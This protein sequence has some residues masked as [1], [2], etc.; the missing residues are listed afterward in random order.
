MKV[1]KYLLKKVL[2][3]DSKF[4][5]DIIPIPRF[6]RTQNEPSCINFMGR[7]VS[8]LVKIT[9][10]QYTTYS[11]ERGGWYMRDNTEVCGL[12][13]VGLLRQACGIDGLIGIDRLLCYRILHELHRFVKFFRTNVSKQGVL[14]EQLRDEVSM[15]NVESMVLEKDEIRSLLR[16]SKLF[17][18]WKNPKNAVA[19]YASG[20][21]KTEMLML[22]MLTCFR[23]VGQ[24]QLLRRMIRYELQR[25]ARVD[26]KMLQHTVSTYN[27]AMMSEQQPLEGQPDD[28]KNICDLTVAVGLGHPLETIFMKTDPLEGLPVLMLFFVITYVPKLSF[29]PSLGSLH[30]VKTG[31]PIDGWPIIA[32]ISTLLKQF[33]P[34]YAKSFLAYVGQFIRVS[35]QTYAARRQGKSEDATRLAADLKNTLVLVEQFCDMS[36]LP[37]SALYEH[38]PQYLIDMC[39]DLP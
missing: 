8:M 5:S 20:S 26:A 22:P 30:K 17:P 15:L 35:V 36:G 2:D 1:N 39:S 37:N 24:A 16:H 25:C 4:Q 38:V 32:G 27:T 9:D 3:T 31:Y 29:N 34:S 12:K 13:A 18:E 33:H 11:L 19:I 10:C 14:L 21:K 6:P 23:R 28:V 7:I